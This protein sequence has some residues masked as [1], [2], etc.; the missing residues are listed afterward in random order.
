MADWWDCPH[1]SEEARQELLLT[2]PPYQREARSKGIPSLGAGAI[3]PV[4]E[5][6]FTVPDFAIPEHWSRAYGL[7]VGWKVT[8]GVWGATNRDTQVTY[9]YSEYCRSE[10]EPIVHAEA[11]RSRGQ[12]IPGA[13]DPA[14][15]GRSQVDGRNLIELYREFGLD[16]TEADNAVESGIYTTWQLLSSGKLKIFASLQNLRAEMRIYRRDEKGKVVKDRDH[17]LHPDTLVITDAGPVPI[18]D[19]EGRTGRVLSRNGSWSRFY[20]ARRTAVD[21]PVVR[22]LFDDGSEVICTPD[23]LFLTSTGGWL[24]AIDLEGHRVYD[25]ISRCVQRSL[26]CER[27]PRPFRN[28][29]ASI[30]TAAASIFR[31]TVRVCTEWFGRPLTGVLSQRDFTF[32]TATATDPIISRE[33]SPCA[34]DRS[35]CASTSTEYGMSFRRKPGMPLQ[36]GTDPKLAESGTGSTTSVCA[37]YCTPKQTSPA[38]AAGVNS[39]RPPTDSTDSARTTVNPGRASYLAWMTSNVLAWFAATLSWRIATLRN[40]PARASAQRSCVSVS[41]AGR[42]DVYCLTVPGTHSFAVSNGILVH[43]CCDAMRYFVMT[44]REVMRGKPQPPR[45][46]EEFINA[47]GYSGGWMG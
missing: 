47:G 11:I 44:G 4:S 39:Q 29:K 43:N 8:A 3:Y 2:I 21:Q 45:H 32:T 27:F 23:H 1:L 14:A 36:H 17:C 22:V 10:A 19:L 37:T 13:I 25:E 16:L 35:T 30:T 15:R 33:I 28:F 20:G 9:L 26:L 24:Q 6:D 46:V 18:R 42:S 40:K 31:T 41:A 12:W 34:M 7:D 38:N 5:S